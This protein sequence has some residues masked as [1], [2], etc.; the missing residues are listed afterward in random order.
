MVIH[1]VQRGDT[2]WKLAQWYG[3]SPQRI[4]SDNAVGNP[5]NLVVGQSLL[6]LTPETVY[7]VQRGD[8]LE[9]VAKRFGVPL[10]T[11]LQYNPDLIGAPYLRAGQTVTIRFQGEKI[12]EVVLNGYAYP[13]IRRDVL[14]R[15]LPCL[16]TLTIFGYGLSAAGDLVPPSD[17]QWMINMAY[18]YRAAPVMLLSSIT[19]DGTFSTDRASRLF[20]NTAYQ[21]RILDQVMA[22]MKERGYLGIDIDFEYIAPEDREYFLSFLTNVTNRMHAEGYFVNTD[23]APKTSG[24]QRGLLYESHDYPSV[25]AISDT[26]LLM[27]Y[28]WGYTYGPPMAVAP[29]NQVRM[30]VEYGVSVIPPEKI[31]MGLPN[32]AYD[33]TLPYE[34]GIS[35]ATTIGNQYAVEMAARYGSEI[36]FDETSQSPYFEYWEPR[37]GNKHIVWFEDVRSIQAKFQL[38]DEFMLLGGGYWNLMR[39]FAQNWSFVAAAYD[40]RKIVAE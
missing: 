28:E 14:Q 9:S 33:W 12:R 15:C 22:V 37:R 35:R 2:V 1:T 29:L 18:Q 39:P 4:I 26:V 16:T 5:R 31:L 34:R 21:N 17:E 11:L 19:E 27:T 38:M 13:Y 6:I 10:I 36:K 32:Y 20:R 23:L 30:V 24:G 3:T 8:T 25:G 7:T 40:I